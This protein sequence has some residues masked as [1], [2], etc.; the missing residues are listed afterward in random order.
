MMPVCGHQDRDVSCMGD[1]E[2]LR[3]HAW[4]SDAYLLAAVAI[5]RVP[6]GLA[7]AVARMAS[8]DGNSEA[9]QPPPKALMRSTAAAMRR[10]RIVTAVCWSV[11]AIVCVWITLR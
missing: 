7:D 4:P 5:S 9:S 10:C 1:F 3:N 8:L 11:K 2:A 6:P